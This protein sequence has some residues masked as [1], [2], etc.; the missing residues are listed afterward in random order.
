M[1]KYTET[2]PI[3]SYQTNQFAE[4]TIP[5]IFNFMLEAAWA[6]AQNLDWGYDLL[7]KHNMFWVLSRLYVEINQLPGWQDQVTLNTWSSGTDGMYAYREFILTGNNGETILTAN[8]AWLILD[9]ES[10]KIVM[11]RDQKETFPRFSGHGVC[12][13]P[14]RLR[15]KVVKSD[16][17]YQPVLFS[18]I[19]INHHFNSVKALER[20]LDD[21]GIEYQHA[22]TPATIEINYLKEGLPGDH[23]AIVKDWVADEKYQST[24]VREDDGAELS[25][26]EIVWRKKD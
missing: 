12:R 5:S 15:H 23:L 26:F 3:R 24:I 22:Y 17:S 11:L 1:E 4:A 13:E 18:D 2:I 14:G 19:D 7:Q 16:L 20:I 8:T 21:Y 9:T 25:T 10:K 6:H